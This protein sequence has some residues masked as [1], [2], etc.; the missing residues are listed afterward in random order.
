MG[1]EPL[2]VD[3]KQRFKSIDTDGSG[4][5]NYEQFV[6]L[7][8]NGSTHMSDQEL[9]LVFDTVCGSNQGSVRFD[10]LV[11]FLCAPVATT[12]ILE[13]EPENRG[14]KKEPESICT[15]GPEQTDAMV[16][17]NPLESVNFQS[18]GV[19]R[20][21]S[22]GNKRGRGVQHLFSSY[23]LQDLG[24][25]IAANL[26]VL[27]NHI[28]HVEHA[29]R[30][31]QYNHLLN[32]SNVLMME[33]EKSGLRSSASLD[34]WILASWLAMAAAEVDSCV[35]ERY[36]TEQRTE[37]RQHF[38]DQYKQTTPRP[39]PNSPPAPLGAMPPGRA[40]RM[41][42]LP[43]MALERLAIHNELRSSNYGETAGSWMLSGER[44]SKRVDSLKRHFDEAHKTQTDHDSIAH[45]LWN[46]MCIYHIAK[47]LPNMNDLPDFESLSRAA[48]PE[49]PSWQR[50]I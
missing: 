21:S 29:T 30:E 6:A 3:L 10:D 43:K 11:D 42:L 48:K 33:A 7:L 15:K 16:K 25:Y 36:T 39:A 18:S 9:R 12:Q 4:V 22:Q 1:L 47:V 31:Y 32:Q 14:Y 17:S 27:R 26:G 41:D 37:L 44:I 45:V 23:W 46:F 8:K 40:A 38:F 19:K 35:F 2:D 5:L 49:P 13:T 20:I 28:L 50:R 34:Q 24:C